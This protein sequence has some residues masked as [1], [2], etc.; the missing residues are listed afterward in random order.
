MA[1]DDG[2]RRVGED[3]FATPAEWHDP[4]RTLRGRMVAP[5]TVWTA[6]G[7]DDAP[8][9]LTVSSVMLAEGEPPTLF[10]LVGPLSALWDAVAS[11]GRFAAHVLDAHQTRLA[12]HFAGR[13]PLAPF[14]GV[15]TSRSDHG[16]LLDAA[17][18][19]ALCLLNGSEDAGHFVLVRAVVEQVVVAAGEH[20]LAL[21]RGRYQTTGPRPRP[22]G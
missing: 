20:P 18:T 4:I 3:G 8:A 22:P 9:G 2:Y 6:Y 13:Y 14:E 11:S 10:G 5:V 16:P 12:D 19:R 17:P 21:Y 7:D 15:A 1:S